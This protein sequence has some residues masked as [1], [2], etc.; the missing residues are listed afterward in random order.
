ME[1]TKPNILIATVMWGR[2]DLFKMFVEHHKKFGFDILVIGSEGDKS[3][4]LCENLGCI[5][6]EH[7]NSPLLSKFNKRI[8]FFMSHE[9]YSHILLLGSDDFI[10]KKGLDVI[11]DKTKD[12]DIIQWKDIY[13][14]DVLS[15]QCVYSKGYE[16]G[17]RVGEPLAPGR[18]ISRKVI[19]KLNG[20]LWDTNR[21]YSPD[22]NLWSK[23]KKFKKSIILSC[24]NEGAIIVDVKT[25]INKTSFNVIKS[26]NNKQL[27][28][29]VVRQKIVDILISAKNS[30]DIDN[31]H[32]NNIRNVK[33]NSILL[34]SGYNYKTSQTRKP[35]PTPK[36]ITKTKSERQKINK[37]KVEK[38]KKKV[39]IVKKTPRDVINE[40]KA[41]KK[42]AIKTVKKGINITKA[43]KRS[44]VIKNKK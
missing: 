37:E 30:T 39:N 44:V 6:I 33:S 15:N 19:N 32:L 36:T 25:E 4:N 38:L 11:V 26:L 27:V 17:P 22:G 20:K 9:E 3:K 40:T 5:Y 7:P 18:C 12:F 10:D 21:T 8:D 2:F 34:S 31:G 1:N 43:K 42:L 16:R 41:E 13:F 14:Y 23:L 24:K 29:D 35:N 28:S